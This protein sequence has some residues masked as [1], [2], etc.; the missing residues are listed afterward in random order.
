M[1]LVSFEKPE[2]IGDYARM[3]GMRQECA[4]AGVNWIP[5]RYHRKPTAP[6]TAY[7]I[8]A[9]TLVGLFLVL[10]HRIQIVHA[11][12]YVASVMALMLKRLTGVRFVFDMRGFWAD[13]RVDG[14]LWPAE[15]RL[16]RMA[17]GVERRLLLGANAVVSLTRAGVDVIR[18]FEYLK[19]RMVRFEVIPTCADLS[20]FSPAK[21]LP[22]GKPF[23]LGYV[24]TVGTWYLFDETVLTFKVLREMLPGAR[25]LVVNRGEHEQIREAISRAGIPGEAV[26]IIAVDHAGMPDLMRRMDASAFFIKPVFSKTGSAPTKLAELLGMGIPILVNSRVGDMARIVLNDGQPVGVVVDTFSRERLEDAVRELVQLS[27]DDAVKSRCRE[28]AERHFTVESGSERYS[29]LY[30]ELVHCGRQ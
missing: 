17:K 15:G 21:S 22:A 2:D 13:E 28:V 12:S 14:G 25:F 3:Y 16:Y 23:T 20:L 24:G 1:F 5:L 11:R 7:D 10:R 8:A 29:K 26:E 18:D 27:R 4:R 9:G 30:R 6:A 19:G